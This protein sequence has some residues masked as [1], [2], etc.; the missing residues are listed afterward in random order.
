MKSHLHLCFVS[1]KIEFCCVTFFGCLVLTVLIGAGSPGSPR[2]HL[3]LNGTADVAELGGVQ[4]D[5]QTQI[6]VHWTQCYGDRAKRTQCKNDVM[7]WKIMPA[8]KDV[9]NTVHE[10][11]L[12]KSR[13]GDE[14][15][16]LR[17][18][19]SYICCVQTTLQHQS[20]KFL[21]SLKEE[22]TKQPQ[23]KR[24]ELVF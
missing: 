11:N 4:R 9:F 5:T 10:N 23:K 2:R 17:Q 7:W 8:K 18:W 24:Q 14:H 22:T 1:R 21:K 15:R 16:L 6:T 20:S 3:T 19:S 12:K 13:L